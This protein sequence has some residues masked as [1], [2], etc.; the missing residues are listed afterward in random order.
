MPPK[1]RASGSKG[2]SP[3]TSGFVGFGAFAVRD[4]E[5]PRKSSQRSVE[6]SSSASCDLTL[7][8]PRSTTRLSVGAP[9]PSKVSPFYEGEDTELQMA[10]K[11]LGKRDRTTKTKA[12]QELLA[13]VQSSRTPA[14]L[15]PAV[16]HFLHFYG[17]LLLDNN[18]RVREMTNTLLYEWVRY[19][20][21]KALASQLCPPSHSSRLRAMKLSRLLCPLLTHLLFH[22]ALALC[23]PLARWLSVSFCLSYSVSLSLS[24]F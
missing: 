16:A 1:N 15:R 2:G 3:T 11:R 24:L 17:K 18:R 14:E 4:E 8:T 13:I 22:L 9:S 23:L 10:L 6:A 21:G 20:R 5:S 12:L 19:K 7:S